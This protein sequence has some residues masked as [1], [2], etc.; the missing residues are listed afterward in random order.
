MVSVISNVFLTIKHLYIKTKKKVEILNITEQIQ[1]RISQSGVRDGDALVFVQGATSAVATVECEDGLFLDIEKMWEKLA[2]QGAFYE[3][4]VRRGD[5]NG[6][7]HLRA[8][9]LGPSL[10]VPLENG[11]LTLGRWQQIILMEFDGPRQK[12]DVVIRIMGSK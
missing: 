11:Q 5:G 10:T 4:N 2:P 3:H 7:S 12:R 1:A 9:L 8:F 6:F